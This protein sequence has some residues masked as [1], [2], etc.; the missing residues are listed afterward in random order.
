MSI[1]DRNFFVINRATTHLLEAIFK[2]GA[3]FN[4]SA[5]TH[6]AG[7][8]NVTCG[9]GRVKHDSLNIFISRAPTLIHQTSPMKLYPVVEKIN[10]TTQ[11]FQPPVRHLQ[12]KWQVLDSSDKLI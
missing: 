3:F 9:V 1:C 8:L 5:V 6:R 4:L 10:N 2:F 12:F 7:N 11:A